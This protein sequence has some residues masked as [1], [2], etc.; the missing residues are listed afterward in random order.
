MYLTF[1]VG[2]AAGKA[3]LRYSL[4]HL[5]SR[6]QVER[7]I[8]SQARVLSRC[9]TDSGWQVAEDLEPKEP[10]ARKA[11]RPEE[12]KAWALTPPTPSPTRS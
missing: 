11:R 12:P 10:K 5:G 1:L 6:R 4:R 3:A 9:G 8:P 7:L 2:N